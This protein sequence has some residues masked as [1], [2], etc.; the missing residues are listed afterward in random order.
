MKK[1]IV[2]GAGVAGVASAY[3]LCK[4]GFAVTLLDEKPAPA[5]GSSHQNGAQLSYA[6]CDALASPSLLAQLP[7]IL[8]KR[9]PAYR[10]T[11]Q[12]DPDF[13][14]WGLRFLINSTSARFSNNTLTL[15]R[16]AL[17][18]HA[19]LLELLEKH[20]IEFD[21]EINGK[22]LLYPTLESCQKHA[23]I[24][25]QKR[26]QGFQLSVLTR[27]EATVIEPAL[28]HYP[29]PIASVVYSPGDAAGRPDVFCQKLVESLQHE[30]GL[31]TQ[32]NQKVQRINHTKDRATGVSFRDSAPL[33]CDTLV[34]T[35]GQ[36][37]DLLPSKDRSLGD[38]WPVQGYSFTA[39]AHPQAMQTS[40][41]DV[42]RKLVFAP[43]GKEL[44]VAGLA[45][46]GQHRFQFMSHRFETLMQTAQAA[47]PHFFGE[48]QGPPKR[49]WSGA[50]YVTPSSQPIIR[51]G[52]LAGLYLNLGHGTLGWT[53][54]LGAAEQVASL[55]NS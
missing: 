6:Y 13:L 2:I 25:E 15:S 14:A 36:S 38:M 34:I 20:P 30:Y 42:K 32:F 33:E 41:T 7:G 27:E 49:V 18:S 28:A 50:R 29:D 44:R 24:L 39:D 23:K 11:L 8:L 52:S 54:S 21:Y 10:C 9:D 5:M 3:M 16:I 40:I 1:A 53:L 12:A 48:D 45:D 31:K 26:Q 17:R 55:I 47:F 19:L 43:L 46:I 4:A 51:R 37:C 35:T 22:M